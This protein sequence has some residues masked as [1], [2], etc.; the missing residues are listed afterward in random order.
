M[1][2]RANSHATVFPSIHLVQ[3]DGVTTP[4]VIATNVSTALGQIEAELPRTLVP[5]NAYYMTLGT[6]PHS[7]Q[8]GNLRIIGASSFVPDPKTPEGLN[9]QIS[10][11]RFP[12]GANEAVSISL[13]FLHITFAIIA[14]TLSFTLVI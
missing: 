1:L 5:S 8:S 4:I 7:C 14:I 10:S 13:P 12:K 3:S 9:N 11:G 2:D 6:A